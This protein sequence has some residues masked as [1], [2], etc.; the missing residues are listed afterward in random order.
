MLSV[1][2]WQHIIRGGAVAS[3]HRLKYPNKRFH[4]DMA[5]VIR[6]V[7]GVILLL[8]GLVFLVTIIGFIVGLFFIIIGIVLIAS[9]ASARGDSERMQR[10]QEQTNLLLQQQMQL[11]AMQVNRA[12]SQPPYAPPSPYAQPQPP[13]PPQGVQADRYCPSCGQ[14]NARASAFCA[15]CGVRPFPRLRSPTTK[16][17]LGPA[18]RTAK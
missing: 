16:S 2:N 10:Q 11:T 14:G 9:G 17:P 15:K 4:F 7:F 6:I 18:R 8:L 5:G 12:P 13:T 1:N 3:V